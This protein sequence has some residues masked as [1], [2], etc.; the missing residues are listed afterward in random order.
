[1]KN[2]LTSVSLNFSVGPPKIIKSTFFNISAVISSL[3]LLELL[4]ID[5]LILLTLILYC[6]SAVSCV[7]FG[8]LNLGALSLSWKN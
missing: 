4:G 8:N 2:A 3:F 6:L 7:I 1:M 5:G